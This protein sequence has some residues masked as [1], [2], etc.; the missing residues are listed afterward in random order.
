MQTLFLEI[1]LLVSL[2]VIVYL[3]AAAVPR[4]E[5]KKV[6][7]EGNGELRNSGLHFDKLDKFLLKLKDKSLRRLKVMVMKTD[8]LI[9]KHL[10]S[11]GE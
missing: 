1:T 3:M 9:S 7:E 4:V 10:K 5:D 11:K 2:A 8:N 6:E